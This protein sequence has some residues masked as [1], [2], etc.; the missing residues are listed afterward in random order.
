[1]I[2]LDDFD[3]AQRLSAVLAVCNRQLQLV[4]AMPLKGDC[5]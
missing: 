2:D 3:G 4:A 5:Q 1:M